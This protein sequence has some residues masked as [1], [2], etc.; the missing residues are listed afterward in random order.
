MDIS[1]RTLGK[2]FICHFQGVC[3]L[4][5]R[6]SAGERKRTTHWCRVIILR[7]KT[8]QNDGF[9]SQEKK[10]GRKRLSH[11]RFRR[12]AIDTF[13]P[14][15]DPLSTCSRRND[16]WPISKLTALEFWKR[17][18]TCDKPHPLTGYNFNRSSIT[19]M[20]IRLTD[21]GRICSSLTYPSRSS[22][23]PSSVNTLRGQ[24]SPNSLLFS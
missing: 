19:S 5:S 3:D 24:S 21:P 17:N 8:C 7:G 12:A 14:L 1:C 20:R 4:V 18:V 16:R 11:T 13:D 6:F 2:H 23:R 15:T 22:L 10:R 9:N